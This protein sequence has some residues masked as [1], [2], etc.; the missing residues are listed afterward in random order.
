MAVYVLGIGGLHH[1]NVMLSASGG[2]FC[3]NCTQAF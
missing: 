2:L 3:S 1:D